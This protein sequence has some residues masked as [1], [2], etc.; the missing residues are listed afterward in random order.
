MAYQALALV[1][2]A[3]AFAA[4]TCSFAGGVITVNMTAD[5]DTAEVQ[6]QVAPNAGRINVLGAGDP[7]CGGIA[8]VSNTTAINITGGVGD[9]TVTIDLADADGATVSW[10][11]INWTVSLGSDGVNG[12]RLKIANGTG[13]D[14]DLKKVAVTMGANGA[15]LNTD[16][17]LDVTVAGVEDFTL[18]SWFTGTGTVLSAAGDTTTGAAFPLSVN[19]WTGNG[20]ASDYGICANGSKGTFSGGAG[21]D[22]LIAG[23]DELNTFSGGLGDDAIVGLDDNSSAVD[24]SGS[25]AAVNVN[26]TSGLATGEGTD[27][28][29]GIDDIIGSAQGDTLTGDADAF[30]N[31]ITPGA[32][33]DKVDGVSTADE[34]TIDYSDATAAVTVD[35]T[36]GTATGGSGNDTLANIEDVQGSDFD[37]TISGTDTFN[38]LFGGDG[39]DLIAGMAGDDDLEGEGGVDTVDYS[40]SASSVDLE[41]SCD[42]AT[43]GNGDIGGTTNPTNDDIFT[44]ENAIL[45]ADD[46]SFAG[47]QFANT[48][49]PMGGQNSLD[50]DAGVSCTTFGGGGDTVD[51]S[52]GYD[53]GVEVNMAGGA[54]AGDA[55]INFENAVGTAF[56]DSITGNDSSNT[57][58]GGKGDDNVRGGGGDDT[59][60]VAGGDDAVRAGSGDDDLYGGAG[61]DYLNGGGGDDFCKSGKGKDKVVK[62]EVGH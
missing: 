16:G 39:N 33:D 54:T 13:V 35:L 50:G 17:D 46:D 34:D 60:K 14:P 12:D 11:T 51:Y 30:G 56:A 15:D 47:N 28:L 37:D 36:A 22:T 20:C 26:L 53:I 9:Q 18:I 44:I 41:L 57:L 58:K 7:T 1:G 10:G 38:G 59:I 8:L 29:S 49:W 43:A 61:N 48:V 40:W 52:V 23:A 32:G 19:G 42:A 24:Y 55:A 5:T 3:P 4:T 45:T 31:Y 2:A 21:N 62:C 25:A 27:T 6:Q